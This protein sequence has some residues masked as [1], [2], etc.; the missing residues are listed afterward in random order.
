[1]FSHDRLKDNDVLSILLPQDD[2]L[3]APEFKADYDKLD[4]VMQ[5][6]CDELRAEI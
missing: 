2:M 5:Q 3:R 1:M 4:L 6:T